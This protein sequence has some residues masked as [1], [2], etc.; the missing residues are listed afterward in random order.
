MWFVP[1][2]VLAWTGGPALRAPAATQYARNACGPSVASHD[3]QEPPDVEMWNA[4]LNAAG[5]HELILAVHRDG[6]RFCFRY[7]W[8]GVVRTVAPTIRVRRGEHFAIRIANDIV[9][10]SAGESAASTAL[11]PCK[12]MSMPAVPMQHWVGYLNHI[13]DDRYVHMHAVDTNLH[14]HGFEGPASME[15]VFLSTLSTPMHAC[16]YDVTVP[17]TQ[18]PGTYIYHTHSHGSSDVEVA[19][20]LDGAWIVEPDAP[21]L[22]RSAEHVLV[23]RY[24]VPFVLDN[25]FA[26]NED[27]YV[28]ASAAHE[29]SLRPA[30][31][32]AYDP[33]N[34]PPW[35]VTYPMRAGGVAMDPTGCNGVVS[36]SLVSVDGAD[37]PASMT[38]PAGQTQLLRLV[39]GTSDSP[40]LL[41]LRD[42]A[43]NV[44]G[45]HVVGLDGVPVSGDV[46][47]PLSGYLALKE[48]MLSPMSRADI[49]LTMPPGATYTLSGEPYC[50]GKDAFFQMHHDLLRIHAA[51]ATSSVAGTIDSAQLDPSNTPAARLVAFARTHPSL[52]HRRAITFTEYLFPKRGRV[53]MHYGFYITDTTNTNFHEHPFW[54]IYRDGATVPS[55]PDIVVQQGAI[56]EWD[57]VNATMET[58][59]FHIHQ[60]A[61]VQEHSYTGVPVTVDTVFVP[62]GS[63]LPNRENPNYPLVK[64][65]I[66]RILLDFRH[67][68]KGEFVFHCHMLF[69]EDHGMMG[70]IRVE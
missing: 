28:R 12:P 55:T 46:E 14:L 63:L 67:V 10:P 8:D 25:P 22:A 11:P 48:L 32:I 47:H 58:H 27:A 38:V 45:L 43:G 19:G 66:T 36:E 60:M 68:P 3:V 37:A 4:P 13:I 52:I 35:P 53:P 18:P 7:T 64:P 31:P 29:G 5:E 21:Q 50:E 49:V 24:R 39:N 16:E 42:A 15:N 57:L 9:G 51:A 23:L 2:L 34:P 26:P 62:I 6:D 44:Q 69:H 59:A 33:F 41:V 70:I 40:K 30:S 54:P 17:R 56:E 1:V 20:G 61:F 65:S